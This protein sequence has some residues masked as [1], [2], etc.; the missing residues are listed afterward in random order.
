MSLRPLHLVLAG[1]MA[2]PLVVIDAAPAQADG[3]HVR[4]SG[5]VHVRV[6]HRRPRVR[7]VY[8]R[9]RVYFGGGVYV[10]FATPPPPP[11][12]VIECEPEPAPYYTEHPAPTPVV[13][14]PHQP[15]PRLG[16]GIMGGHYVEDDGRDGD[17]LGLFARLR[18]STALQLE[19]EASKLEHDD[20]TRLDKRLGAGL[21]VDLAPRSTLSPYVVGALGVGR[22]QADTYDADIGYGEIGAGLTWRLSDR[23]HLAG[24]FRWGRVSYEEVEAQP[25]AASAGAPLPPVAS[26]DDQ[27]YTRGRI[28]AILYF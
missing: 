16:L 8:R 9:P 3:V 10:R 12:P 17:E 28:A 25:V 18:L 20:D 21:V 27:D 2:A 22:V 26:P 23:V 5:G 13:V 11:P 7:R 15:L 19:L 14:A 6:G 4:V 1:L 24:D